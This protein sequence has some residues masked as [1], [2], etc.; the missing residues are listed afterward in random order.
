MQGVQPSLCG[1]S[2]K[3]AQVA[4]QKQVIPMPTA[5]GLDK[6][7]ADALRDPQQLSRGDNLA[8]LKSGEISKRKGFELFGTFGFGKA[9]FVA[10]D[11]I[12][13]GNN[14]IST[15]YRAFSFIN[16]FTTSA[17]SS[18]R[19][20]KPTMQE[21]TFEK[22]GAIDDASF[23]TDVCVDALDFVYLA[24]NGVIY[25]CD[26]N[27]NTIRPFPTSLKTGRS[28]TTR[29][30]RVR[31]VNNT[32]AIT[33]GNSGIIYSLSAFQSPTFTN[34][35]LGL[36][37]ASSS[38]FD[39]IGI[40]TGYLV[41]YDDGTDL[42]VAHFNSSNVLQGT[43]T[44]SKT[45][46]VSCHLGY[47]TTSNNYFTVGV[48]RSSGTSNLYRV[49]LS[50]MTVDSTGD[51]GPCFHLGTVRF[52]SPAATS[53]FKCSG[54]VGD[55]TDHKVQLG[56]Q[57][58][59]AAS[60]TLGF[61]NQVNQT[62]LSS[63]PISTDQHTFGKYITALCGY[64]ST[65]DF[66]LQNSMAAISWVTDNLAAAFFDGLITNGSSPNVNT[67]I[68]GANGQYWL[69][70]LG[71]LSDG[72][73][74]ST[75]QVRSASSGSISAA[76]ATFVLRGLKMRRTQRA[77][78]SKPVNFAGN[79]YI[80]ANSIYICN[81]SEYNE[82]GFVIYPNSPDATL[83]HGGGTLPGATYGFA[84]T[85]EWTDAQGRTIESAPSFKTVTTSSGSNAADYVTQNA[86]FSTH[87]KYR[88]NFYRTVPDGSIY[89]FVGSS[90]G[91]VISEDIAQADLET[92]RILY[93]TGGVAENIMP[94]NVNFLA[95]AK[96]R[97]WTFE[98]G[99]YSK[100]WFSKKVDSSFLPA[101]SDLLT[102]EVGQQGGKLVGVAQV[103][104]K[105]I[106]FKESYIYVIVG[107]GPTDTLVGE[108]S[109]PSAISQ[110]IGCSSAKSILET[111]MGV[112]FQ[113]PEGI[114]LVDRS[115]QVQFVGRPVY[116]ET[117][118]TSS[119]YLQDDNLCLF[120]TESEIWV[121][122]AT[123]GAWYRW[124]IERVQ[125]MYLVDGAIH[126]EIGS[127]V[128]QSSRIIDQGSGFQDYGDAGLA[129]YDQAIKLGQYQ[130][131]GIQGYQRVYRLLL[132]G[133]Q[134][135]STTALT[136]KTYFDGNS[137]ATDTLSITA[138]NSK[139]GNRMAFEVRPSVQ[140]CETM[141]LEVI[142]TG[143]DEGIKI[144]A[145]SAEIGVIGGAGRRGSS[146]RAI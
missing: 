110:G 6:G 108:F 44:L 101:F 114:Y 35:S 60:Y 26:E 25:K 62:T 126:L 2:S 47:V 3:G 32:H 48:A 36:T 118:V 66:N 104:D 10:D 93:T 5:G 15:D 20:F 45:N 67:E 38:L 54:T 131:A 28:V 78:F 86:P 130:F 87:T 37:I 85:Y 58:S 132:T 125:E 64:Q 113:S 22:V 50:T 95:F 29:D 116:G 56:S 39:A 12:V 123:T 27:F 142:H 40:G 14:K 21:W 82:F 4:L 109:Q 111:P 141:E 34:V 94:H 89:Y 140:K 42:K 107:D 120:S 84:T 136:V 33:P 16:S 103:D 68:T 83:V 1:S 11:V 76:D 115:L 55:P 80:A 49:E 63:F 46:A 102:L 75:L 137:T 79:A 145:V 138:A 70:R 57:T 127:T 73:W 88:Q 92:R 71:E 7:T 91:A 17:L 41:S 133:A 100:V 23:I 122:Y 117:S 30:G 8:Q 119:L 52:G 97:M 139:S 61:S 135:T 98:R 144:S 43:V 74:V 106:I 18:N 24:T 51:T 112:F 31:F 96:N 143:N 69:P 59:W 53:F 124:T 13:Y 65:D 72:T 77:D 129:N 81:G 19:L 128:D 146:G 99:N 134:T 90:T 121:Y 105:V 9:S